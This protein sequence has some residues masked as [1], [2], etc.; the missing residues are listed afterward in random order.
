M[1]CLLGFYL[2]NNVIAYGILGV[3][4]MMTHDKTLLSSKYSGHIYHFQENIAIYY[5]FL[6]FLVSIL[7]AINILLLSQI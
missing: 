1:I 7:E 5:M 2:Y 6:V 4:I 3:I